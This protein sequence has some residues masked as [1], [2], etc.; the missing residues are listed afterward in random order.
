MDESF[1]PQVENKEKLTKRILFAD[2]MDMVR[3]MCI[4][5]LTS[6]GYL[7][8]AVE[9]GQLLLDKLN[10]AKEKYDLV[11]TDNNMGMPELKGIDVLR[12]IRGDERFKDLP[13]IVS[14]GDDVEKKVKELGGVYVSKG[15]G[16]R[17]LLEN[18]KNLIN[19]QKQP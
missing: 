2:D 13:V 19:P 8:D 6:E 16:N 11:L 12:K 10:E 4:D 5:L 1:K 18:I 14:S 7:V 15:S 3:E 9:N 17:N